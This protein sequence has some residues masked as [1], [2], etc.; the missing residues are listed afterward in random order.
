[1]HLS[2]LY[3]LLALFTGISV[4]AAE[5]SPATLPSDWIDPKTGHR[6]IRLTPD[7]GGS[8]LYFHQHT[9]TPEG[10]RIV[11]NTKEG[12]ATVDLTTLGQGP[13]KRELVGPGIRG[14][15]ATAWRSREAYFRR[16]GENSIYALNLDTKAVREVVKLPP[17]LRAGATALN[18]D[19]TL[20]VG[21]AQDPDGKTTPRLPP[22]GKPVTKVRGTTTTA[23]GQ[24]VP[25]APDCGC[26]TSAR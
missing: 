20:L 10:D 2:R 5:P 11:S 19:E 24:S 8:R 17:N 14:F 12:L 1:M 21:I 18:C 26:C 6:A 7:D 13:I 4:I 23:P 25:T 16:F 9:Y 15:I 3:T 22:N